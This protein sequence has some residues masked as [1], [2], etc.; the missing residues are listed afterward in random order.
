MNGPVVGPL[1]R[2]A[3]GGRNWEGFS[4][5]PYLSGKL[6]GATVQ[7]VQESVI[8][9]VKHFVGY[10]QETQR[11]GVDGGNASYSANIDDKTMH[12]LYLWPFMDAVRAGAGAIM[13]S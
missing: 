11:T 3:L 10:E 8:T 12:E 13:C 4:P 5:D 7:G 9:A 2:M 6:V 1:G